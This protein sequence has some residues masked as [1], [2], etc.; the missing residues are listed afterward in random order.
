MSCFQGSF[1]RSFFRLSRKI[2][3]GINITT[4]TPIIIQS[5]PEN[6]QKEFNNIM[7]ATKLPNKITA[8][9]AQAPNN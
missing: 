9:N 8:L 4:A 1:S 2:I 5:I 6:E 7:S 3:I